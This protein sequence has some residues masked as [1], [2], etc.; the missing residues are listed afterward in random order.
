V[1]RR[2]RRACWRA[3]ND[4]VRPALSKEFGYKNAL[5]VPRVQKIVINIGLG[6]AIRQPKLLEQ[7]F[8]LLGNISGQ[9]PVVTRAKKSI[10]TFKLRE[11]MK[12]GCMVTLRGPRMWEFLDRLFSVALPRTRDFR[13]VSRKAFDGRGNFTLGVKAGPPSGPGA[14][15]GA[16]VRT[17]RGRRAGE[18]ALDVRVKVVGRPRAEDRGAVDRQRALLRGAP[19]LAAAVEQALQQAGLPHRRSRRRT[20]S[21]SKLGHFKRILAAEGFHSRF[22]FSSV[23]RNIRRKNT[24]LAASRRW[25]SAASSLAM[26]LRPGGL[27]EQAHEVLDDLLDA[28]AE[29]VADRQPDVPKVACQSPSGRPAAPRADSGSSAWWSCERMAAGLASPEC[30]SRRLTVTT[31][32]VGPS[33]WSACAAP[34]VRTCGAS[35]PSPSM[36]T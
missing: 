10:A 12:I 35:K 25:P 3:T 33:A 15:Q 2:T 17:R 4:N 16:W 30:R 19:H 22:R 20:A 6:E 13:G 11:N 36:A 23:T 1:T 21:S 18:P 32:I 5:T 7:A 34:A 26:A 24:R 28:L 14:G 31:P 27:L 8:E 29:A 9:R